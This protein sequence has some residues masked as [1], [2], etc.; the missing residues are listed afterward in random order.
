MVKVS[1]VM[2]CYNGEK[3]LREAIDSVFAQT[4]TD[5]EIIFWDNYSNDNSAK[6]ACS[7]DSN[8][9]KYF[10]SMSF[11]SLGEARRNAVTVASGEWVAFLDCDDNWYPEKLA[12][13]MAAL[14]NT[15]YVFAYAGILEITGDGIPIRTVVPKYRSGRLLGHLLNQFDV[16]MVTPMIR[17]SCLKMYNIN[18]EPVITASEEYNLFIRL[19]ARG[20]VLVQK[21]ILGSYRVYAGSLTDRQINKWA[22]ERRYTLK[23]LLEE[24]PGIDQMYKTELTE[25]ENRGTYYEVRY[26]MSIGDRVNAKRVMRTISVSAPIY[27]LLYCSLFIDGLWDLMHANHKI[28]KLKNLIT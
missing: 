21:N 22:F 1:V 8:K 27:T 19:A 16:N 7:Y 2:N 12:V 10:K 11:T 17:R 4:F 25:A 28:R 9:L 18:F 20:D 23:Q 6:I 14:Q 26:L 15:N 24:N 3:Y 13:Q 5:W